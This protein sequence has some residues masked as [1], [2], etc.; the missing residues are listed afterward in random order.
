MVCNLH[1]SHCHQLLH[2]SVLLWQLSMIIQDEDWWSLL[3]TEIIFVP[4]GVDTVLHVLHSDD[5]KKKKA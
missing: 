2:C 5:Y 4:P 1:T 3:Q